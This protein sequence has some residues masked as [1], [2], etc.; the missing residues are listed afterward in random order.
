MDNR[1]LTP[2]TTPKSPSSATMVAPPAP[3]SDTPMK[4]DHRPQPFDYPDPDTGELR[5]VVSYA[6]LRDRMNELCDLARNS[7]FSGRQIHDLID[8]T[9][10]YATKEEPHGQDR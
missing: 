10:A 4:P 3:E 7:G 2:D 5:E 8:R 1:T 6:F 9:P